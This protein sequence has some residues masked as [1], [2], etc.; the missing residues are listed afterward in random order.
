MDTIERLNKKERTNVVES[1]LNMAD[2]QLKSK[3]ACVRTEFIL[4][5]QDKLFLLVYQN[6][7]NWERDK[8]FFSFN[9]SHDK[10]IGDSVS[11]ETDGSK[12]PKSMVSKVVALRKSM[13]TPNV[14]DG[15][16]AMEYGVIVG[17]FMNLLY[18]VNEA[19]D[20]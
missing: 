12:F 7:G 14:D 2:N 8:G 16:W 15:S 17:D 3:A 13:A 10:F 11:I 19:H 5:W 4:S 18:K 6:S 20:S 1:A 9:L